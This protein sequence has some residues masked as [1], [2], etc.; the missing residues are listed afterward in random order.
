MALCKIARYPQFV[1]HFPHKLNSMQQA[2]RV[3]VVGAAKT[4]QLWDVQTGQA[5]AV[6][7]VSSLNSCTQ[8]LRIASRHY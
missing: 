1:Q 3:F 6:G 7:A 8:P 5:Q 2:N 4:I